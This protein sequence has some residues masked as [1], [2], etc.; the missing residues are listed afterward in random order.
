MLVKKEKAYIRGTE[1]G[2]GEGRRERE[3][4]GIVGLFLFTKVLL[5][6]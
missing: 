4:M 5:K 3:G 2:G 6:D 1:R